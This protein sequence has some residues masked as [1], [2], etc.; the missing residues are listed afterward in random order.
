MHEIYLPRGAMTQSGTPTAPP[1]L[2]LTPSSQTLIRIITTGVASLAALDSL[3]LLSDSFHP[4]CQLSGL[5][6]FARVAFVLRRP[7]PWRHGFV[8]VRDACQKLFVNVDTE[9]W[10]LR[11]R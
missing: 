11:Y 1:S 5:C 7:L 9:A 3:R 2:S 4:S 10:A 6:S 8:R